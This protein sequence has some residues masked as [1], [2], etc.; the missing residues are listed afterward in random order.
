M[1][2][3][4]LVYKFLIIVFS[5][6]QSKEAF[7]LELKQLSCA[8]V[9]IWSFSAV[10]HSASKVFPA[11]FCLGFAGRRKRFMA[12]FCVENSAVEA[13]RRDESCE[14]PLFLFCFYSK[15]SLVDIEIHNMRF[16]SQMKV[17]VPSVGHENKG[18]KQTKEGNQ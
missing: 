6:I 11:V 2:S 17:V 8:C 16:T 3:L 4:C 7:S 9:F 1:L 14:E 5:Q 10:S 15:I 12:C 18:S 13:S